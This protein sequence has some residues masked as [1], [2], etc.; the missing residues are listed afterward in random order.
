MKFIQIREEETHLFDKL[1]KKKTIKSFIG[2]NRVTDFLFYNLWLF[3]IAGLIILAAFFF[4][5]DKSDIKILPTVETMIKLTDVQL[6]VLTA[7]IGITITIILLSF[8]ISFKNYGYYSFRA[9]FR[10]EKVRTLLTLFVINI[11]LSVYAIAYYNQTADSGVYGYIL[12]YLIMFLFVVIVFALFPVTKSILLSSQSRKHIYKIIQEIDENYFFLDNLHSQKTLEDPDFLDSD[13]FNILSDICIRAIKEGDSVTAKLIINSLPKHLF[14]LISTD[15]KK[16][17]FGQ[18]SSK[19]DNFYTTI[20]QTS[21]I[22][23]NENLLFQIIARYFELF[24]LRMTAY[25]ENTEENHFNRMDYIFTFKRIYETTL[26]FN[27]QESA[28]FL[29]K[30]HHRLF[31][32]IIRQYSI[33]KLNLYS[34]DYKKQYESSSFF[35]DNCQLFQDVYNEASKLNINGHL[36][37]ILTGFSVIENAI[38]ESKREKKEK[39]WMI[40]I[41]YTSKNAVINDMCQVYPNILRKKFDITSTISI[42]NELDKTQSNLFVRHLLSYSKSLKTNKVFTEQ[43]INSLKATALLC[44]DKFHKDN[45]YKETLEILLNNM[46]SLALSINLDDDLYMKKL[47]LWLHHY[48]NFLNDKLKE[49]IEDSDIYKKSKIS[50]SKLNLADQFKSD[51]ENV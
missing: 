38:V 4:F 6:K 42:T 27:E 15:D 23:K 48:L 5:F 41:L 46:Y 24:D 49:K 12:F 40:K 19:L 51:L 21:C 22:A 13:E 9:F 16:Y 10:N 1:R 37:E 8:Q 30:R 7:L 35:I 31:D 36:D 44:I 32:K 20:F 26:K 29:I 28:R 43:H 50:L 2:E 45:I 25:F 47:Y 17:L 14:F 34:D 11:F 18:V 3:L 39:L 33:D